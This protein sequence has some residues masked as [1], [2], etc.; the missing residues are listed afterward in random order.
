MEK[1]YRIVHYINQFFG[2]IGGEESALCRP[3]FREGA[4]G[5]G[6]AFQKNM[7]EKFEIVATCICG[8]N[9]IAQNT[10]EAIEEILT[11]IVKYEP[12]AVIAGPAFMAG[13]YGSACGAVCRAVGQRLHIPVVTGM[14]EE[15]PGVEIYRKDC[16]IVRTKDSAAGMRDAAKKMSDL[17]KR[18]MDG[19]QTP[20][21][22]EDSY[23]PRRPKKMANL[24]WNQVGVQ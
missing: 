4:V 11:G 23:F 8:D 17:L 3:E 1:R 24:Y 10:E 14:H 15:N 19:S 2:Q 20:T 16:Y 6:L 18:I 7:G 12:D 5:P 21:A 9:Y 22:K 13:R